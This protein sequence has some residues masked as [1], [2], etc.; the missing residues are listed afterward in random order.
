MLQAAKHLLREGCPF[1]ISNMR[2]QDNAR[3]Y[4]AKIKLIS[5]SSKDNIQIHGKH[6]VVTH[7]SSSLAALVIASVFTCMQTEKEAEN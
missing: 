2:V 6:S 1:G 4:M 7:H 3:G 5:D